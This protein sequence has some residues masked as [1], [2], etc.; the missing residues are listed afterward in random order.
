MPHLKAEYMKTQEEFEQVTAEQVAAGSNRDAAY[1]ESATA[2]RTPPS[3]HL[4]S[5][6]LLQ[7]G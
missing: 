1:E 3:Q 6:S 7:S 4:T 5:I 2:G